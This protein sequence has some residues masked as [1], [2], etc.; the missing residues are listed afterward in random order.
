MIDSHS[1]IQFSAY[2]ADREEV[3]KRAREAGVKM[4]AIGTRV[5]TSL[6]GVKVAKEY[7]EDV[8]GATAGFHPGHLDAEEHFDKDELRENIKEKFDIDALREVAKDKHVL[9]IGECGLDYYR[10][11]GDAAKASQIKEKQ[12]KVFLAQIELAKELEKPLV[13]HCRSAF[14][15][16]IEILVASRYSLITTPGV[17]HFFSG[18]K[19]AARELMDLGFYIAFGGVITFTKDY[20][21][22]VK[23][24]PLERIILETDAPYV[25]PA[26]YRGKRNEPAYMVETAKKVAELK[27]VSYEEVLTVTE[28][29]TKTLFR[30]L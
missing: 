9:A 3:I 14:S 7:P 19:D 11:P 22:V 26:P 30:L 12:K 8:L 2:D 15:D 10:L 4:I 17:I 5:S 24:V 20:D 16:L 13:I 21:E 6:E 18:T 27:G 25:A 1:H 23:F 29:N 28:H